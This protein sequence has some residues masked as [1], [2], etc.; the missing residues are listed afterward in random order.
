VSERPHAGT[1]D[2][3][4]APSTAGLGAITVIFFTIFAYATGAGALLAADG[5]WRVVNGDAGA[6]R[7]VIGIVLLAPAA[8]VG[9]HLRRRSRRVLS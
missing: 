7:L 1:T 4:R 2:T 6:A 9:G 3:G 5:L 8:L